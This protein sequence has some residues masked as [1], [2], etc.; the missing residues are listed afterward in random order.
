MEPELTIADVDVEETRMNSVA[1][2][3]QRSARGVSSKSQGR[4]P[5]SVPTNAAPPRIIL[6]AGAH[7]ASRAYALATARH[8]HAVW[9]ERWLEPKWLQR[10]GKQIV[11]KH[12]K[13]AL[14]S[15]LRPFLFVFFSLLSPFRSVLFAVPFCFPFRFD[16]VPFFRSVLFPFR[17]VSVPDCFRSVPFCFPF[18]FVFVPRRSLSLSLSYPLQGDS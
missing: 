11:R 13:N 14:R 18:R 5:G 9:Y 4:R 17:F 15:K 12:K 3:G 7:L 10:E 1:H 16:S 8:Y 6:R 2:G